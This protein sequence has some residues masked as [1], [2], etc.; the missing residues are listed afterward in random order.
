MNIMSLTGKTDQCFASIASLT[1]DTTKPIDHPD[2]IKQ[3]AG[4]KISI[5]GQTPE[6]K[7][8]FLN[9]NLFSRIKIN[10]E[11]LQSLICYLF[12]FKLRKQHLLCL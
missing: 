8:N 4:L 7:V 9:T 6:T 12:H 3:V 11:I 5:F 1:I 10:V 2:S